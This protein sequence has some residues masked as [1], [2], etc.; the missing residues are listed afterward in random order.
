ME[1]NDQSLVVPALVYIGAVILIGFPATALVF[2]GFWE[3]LEVLELESAVFESVWGIVLVLVSLL[4]GLQLAVE[5]AALQLGGIE[6]LGRGSRRMTLVRYVLL[7]LGAFCVLAGAT[8]I[9]LS[10][11]L[12][13]FGPPAIAL[14]ALVGLAG[15]VVLYRSSRAFLAGYSNEA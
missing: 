11:A 8:W 5:A 4:I 1:R 10:T 14:G 7:T 13:G 2:S 12:A 3:L 15:L 6:A 9:G